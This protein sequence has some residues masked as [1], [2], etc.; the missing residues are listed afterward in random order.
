MTRGRTKTLVLALLAVSLLLVGAFA[1]AHSF[2]RDD[3]AN[4][5]C[6]RP[7]EDCPYG[8]EQ[9]AVGDGIVNREDE[10]WSRPLDGSG[11]G[12]TTGYGNGLRNGNGYGRGLCWQN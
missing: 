10:D 8:I 7:I 4:G 11:Y 1:M 12:Q 6:N 9:D 3:P 2:G 5:G